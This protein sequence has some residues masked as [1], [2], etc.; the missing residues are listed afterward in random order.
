MV[1]PTAQRLKQPP[2]VEILASDVSSAGEKIRRSVMLG[3]QFRRATLPVLLV[4]LRDVAGDALELGNADTSKV[5]LRTTI[6]I[7]RRQSR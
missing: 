7:S 1:L 5:R 2:L 3:E 6:I 4:L